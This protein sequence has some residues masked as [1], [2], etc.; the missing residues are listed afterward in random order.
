[1]FLPAVLFPA[2]AVINVNYST[3]VNAIDPRM[4]LGNNSGVW[5]DPA[6]YS[7]NASRIA[8]AGSTF[9]RFPG[10]SVSNEYHWNG[11]G[12]YDADHV[13]HPSAAS[14]SPGFVVE[15][16]Y[17][18]STSAGYGKPARLTDGDTSSNSQ[19]RSDT[20]TAS[21]AMN[22][23][24]VIVDLGSSQAVDQFKIFWGDTYA[25]SYDI[26]YW[27]SGNW[28]WAVYQ[29][30]TDSWTTI[31]S[32]TNGAGGTD[33]RAIPSTNARIFRIRMKTSSG[34]GYKMNEIQLWG[35]GTMKTVNVNNTSQ[36]V[37]IASPTDKANTPIGWTPAYD[38]E[39]FMSFLNNLGPGSKGIVTVNFGTGT[40]EEAAAWV[41]YAKDHGYLSRISYWQIGNENAG[42][43]EACG[44][45]DAEYYALRYIKFVDAMKTVDNSIKIAGPVLGDATTA[46][47]LYDGMSFMDKFFQVLQANG[48]LGYLDALDFHLY[49]DWQNNNEANSLSTPNNWASGTNYK[50]IVDSLMVNYY[51]NVNAKPVILS[52]YNSGSATVLSM[53]FMNAL[54]IT[55]W[56]GEYMKA[57]GPRA[58]GNLW[59][60]MNNDAST[61]NYDHGFM[62]IG[63]QTGAYKYQARASYWGMYII[64][65][66]FACPDEYGNTLVS[67]SSNQT[68][69]PVYA[70]KRN[71]GALSLMVV[72]K[73]KNNAYSSTINISGYTPD[74]SAELY[75]FA[76]NASA[77][78]YIQNYVWH[79]DATRSYADPD[80]PPLEAVYPSAAGSFSFNF[81]AYSISVFKFVPFGSTPTVTPT[82]TATATITP[83]LTVTKTSTQ[84]RTATPTGTETKTAT[85]SPT[86]TIT[87]TITVSPTFT[88]ASS[89]KTSY[90]RL[91]I[92]PSLIKLSASSKGLWF[93]NLTKHTVI[94]FYNINGEEIFSRYAD[95]PQGDYFVKMVNTGDPNQF[96]PGIYVY[97]ITSRGGLIATGKFAVVR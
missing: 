93:H 63:A 86:W 83:T 88:P 94:K 29:S 45:V 91:Y 66:Y 25:V 23:P 80:L 60:I 82:D 44:P 9:I 31:L 90:D 56:L 54:W 81:P 76:A 38:F 37:T 95:T 39:G 26:Q 1:M 6:G 15:P 11:S 4:L 24:Y 68:L 59:D 70:A 28:T 12:S 3:E 20:T 16:N 64:N 57:F 5:L 41:Q 7:A 40:Y 85:V 10:G 75:T 89:A 18:G 51:G 27:A 67:A 49:P 77:P 71:D 17:R 61:G 50:S 36:S 52:E 33:V 48:K 84:T 87:P 30:P 73:D 97:M 55:N 42:L 34:I 13:W 47:E 72:N 43:W 53:S 46:S 62:E 96:P 8:A 32:V 69:L 65:N 79:D 22:N 35:G 58:C 19:W 74:P 78:Y 2:S 92:Y 21:S 14:Y